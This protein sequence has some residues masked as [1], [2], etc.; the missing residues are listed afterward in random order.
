MDL[1]YMSSRLEAL[2]QGMQMTDGS[3]QRNTIIVAFI[4]LI[5]T[6][7]V[8]GVAMYS[9]RYTAEY[10]PTIGNCP[11]YWDIDEDGTCTDTN[12][13]TKTYDPA[14]DGDSIC[15]KKEWAR[16]NNVTWDGITNSS[17]DCS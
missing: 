8:V 17:V 12:D 1:V 2:S 5:M 3:F 4:V 13:N 11:D 6:L 14:I 9:S 10:P 7:T 16:E 15:Q